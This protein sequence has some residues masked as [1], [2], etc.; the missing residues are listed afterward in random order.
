MAATMTA[1]RHLDR[2]GNP[3]GDVV[4][5]TP[6]A[7]AGLVSRGRVVVVNEGAA[8][9]DDDPGHDPQPVDPDDGPTPG[10]STVKDLLD[11]VAA[12]TLDAGDV[13]AAEYARPDPRT[14]ILDRL[15]GAQHGD[16]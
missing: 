16:E 12:G 13:L 5:V 14:T 9:P 2:D 10:V 8:D 6:R 11:A 3:T 4:H 1:I 15:Q 7:A